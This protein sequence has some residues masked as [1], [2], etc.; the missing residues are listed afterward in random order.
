MD[1]STPSIP[2]TKAALP[3]PGR[4]RGYDEAAVL[5]AALEL[6]WRQGFEATSLVDLT[7]AMGI[8]R[9]S[10]YGCFGSKHGVLMAAL[11]CYSDAAYKALCASAQGPS[12]EAVPRMMTALADPTG[13]ERGCMFANTVSEVAP[14]DPEVADLSR[15][16]LAR[17]EALFARTLDPE[18]PENATDRAGA[19]LALAF[20]TIVL[21]KAGVPAARLETMLDQ[22]RVL[23][24]ADTS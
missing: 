20:G 24:E 2:A 18:K 6:F 11:Q 5:N 1:T 3:G 12:V 7:E 16:H 9:S 19:I 10:F 17:I 4:P 13:G 21:R 8:S 15:R 23:I 22:A 14:R